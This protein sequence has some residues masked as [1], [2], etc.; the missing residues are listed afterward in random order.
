MKLT[1]TL[2]L[3]S[4]CLVPV[5]L[6][7]ADEDVELL[8]TKVTKLVDAKFGGDWDRALRHYAGLGEVKGDTLEPSD[9]KALL[10][11]ADVGNGITRAMQLLDK[12]GDKVISKAELR[13]TDHNSHDPGVTL[14]E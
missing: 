7:A 11:D 4:L 5:T 6:A 9:L 14:L 2:L 10:K 12:D 13:W 1:V 3:A 8:R